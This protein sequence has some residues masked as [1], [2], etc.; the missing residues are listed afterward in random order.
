[1]VVC[2]RVHVYLYVYVSCVWPVSLTLG[3]SGIGQGF[4]LV[5]KQCFRIFPNI[6]NWELQLL[7][8]N[9][10]NVSVLYNTFY[11]PGYTYI[12]SY[13]HRGAWGC[14]VSWRPDR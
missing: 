4:P 5:R 8:L 6:S 9:I 13:A 7:I 11:I 10:P 3:G 14:K 12:D 2:V 1:M